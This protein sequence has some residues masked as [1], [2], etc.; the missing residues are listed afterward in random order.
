M[1]RRQKL[2][3]LQEKG[4][5]NV[6]AQTP[7]PVQGITCT[8]CESNIRFTLTSFERVRQV[9]ADHRTKSVEVDHDPALVT[10]DKIPRDV[11][12]RVVGS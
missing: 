6:T 2:S 9:T 7:R 11:G 1:S 4:K 10:V 8:G 12:Y 5:H 3:A